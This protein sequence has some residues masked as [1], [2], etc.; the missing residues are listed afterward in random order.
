M[1]ALSIY[2]NI[3]QMNPYNTYYK[4]LKGLNNNYF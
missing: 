3:T 4:Y 2:E 1:T